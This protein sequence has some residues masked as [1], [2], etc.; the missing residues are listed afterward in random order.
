MDMGQHLVLHLD[1]WCRAYTTH[2]SKRRFLGACACTAIPELGLGSVSHLRFWHT[3]KRG[4]PLAQMET[5]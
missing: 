3:M 4:R 5:A 2:G 1:Q